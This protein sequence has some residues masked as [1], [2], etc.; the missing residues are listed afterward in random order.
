MFTK[1]IRNQG[2][3]EPSI[4][5][6]Q[7]W[8]CLG[9][10]HHKLDKD[11]AKFLLVGLKFAKYGQEYRDFGALK[12]AKIIDLSRACKVTLPDLPGHLLAIQ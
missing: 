4:S 12:S 1:G 7:K 2:N 10:S 8:C 6:A 5:V 11:I 9:V 3:F